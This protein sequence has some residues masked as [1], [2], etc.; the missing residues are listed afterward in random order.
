MV[1][2][3]ILVLAAVF[4]YFGYWPFHRSYP[5]LPSIHEVRGRN[6]RRPPGSDA[7]PTV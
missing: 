1:L 5:M 7:G 6:D 4:W 2:V 3:G